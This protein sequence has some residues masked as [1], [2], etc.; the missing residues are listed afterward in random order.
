MCDRWRIFRVEKSEGEKKYK[1]AKAWKD[2][3]R[4]VFKDE[5]K[6]KE[7]W[8]KYFELLL[9]KENSKV[10][11]GDGIPNQAITSEISKEL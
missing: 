6:I 2:E 11:V 10:V 4:E 8:E 9:N 1:M 7:R 3:N 5:R